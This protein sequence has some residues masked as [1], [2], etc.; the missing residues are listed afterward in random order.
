[1][2]AAAVRR[3]LVEAH[4]DGGLERRPGDPVT[5]GPG[6]AED[7]EPFERDQRR[8][9]P[10]RRQALE[11][12]LAGP[13]GIEDHQADREPLLLVRRVGPRVVE[14]V[15]DVR[16][17]AMGTPL[18]VVCLGRAGSFDGD[19]IGVDL[20]RDAVEQDAT[21]RAGRPSGPTRRARRVSVSASTTAPR[22]WLRTCS[23]RSATSSAAARMASDRSRSASPKSVGNMARHAAGSID[24]PFMT[25]R[26]STRWDVVASASSA[27]IRATSGS[28][29]M[30]A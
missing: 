23:P 25:A 2:S 10:R 18:A 21:L 11:P 17:D 5:G 7:V 8:P 1:M 28:A 6:A 4:P 20:R 27:A 13:F 26:A 12:D 29:W 16:A 9:V 22:T 3:G 30:P 14:L 24:W 15:Q 19:V